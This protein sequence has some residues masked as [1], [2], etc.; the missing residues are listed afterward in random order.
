MQDLV[1]VP[2][3]LKML[4]QTVKPVLHCSNNLP[5]FGLTKHAWLLSKQI[6]VGYV[7]GVKGKYALI[8]KAELLLN[9]SADQST[10]SWLWW[11]VH[12]MARY[13]NVTVLPSQ[14]VQ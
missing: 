6:A 9:P 3:S 12:H 8:E 5:G 7:W 10:I 2:A 1:G 14:T 4:L 13:M 11:M